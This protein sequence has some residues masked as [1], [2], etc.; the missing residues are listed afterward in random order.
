MGP[1]AGF[2]QTQPTIPAGKGGGDAGSTVPVVPTLQ[3]LTCPAE[4]RVTVSPDTL[5]KQLRAATTTAEVKKLLAPL[6]FEFG[7]DQ[8]DSCKAESAPAAVTLDV[9][10]ARIMSSETVD[11]VL[12]VRGKVCE[13][14]PLLAGVVLHPLAEKNVYCLTGMPFLPGLDT[15]YSD[16]PPRVVFAFEY[17]TDPVRQVFKVDFYRESSRSEESVISYWEAQEGTLEE[18]FKLGVLTGVASAVV[19]TSVEMSIR[20]EGKEFPRRLRLR[21]RARNCGKEVT[22]PSGAVQ[23]DNE[24]SEASNEV[25]YCYKRT[26][27]QSPGVYVECG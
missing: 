21:E 14:L 6:H 1:L 20:A 26:G 3:P 9:F 16:S 2:A 25:V 12:Q 23:Y 22:L 17:L 18:I 27:P 19:S 11:V 15:S 8:A 24:C 10:R 13:Y 5:K 7:W 4:R